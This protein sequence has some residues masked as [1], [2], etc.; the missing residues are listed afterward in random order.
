MYRERKGVALRRHNHEYITSAS[1]CGNWGNWSSFNADLQQK[2]GQED[3]I[4]REGMPSANANGILLLII[5]LTRE[6]IV[7]KESQLEIAT[8]S[9]SE[10]VFSLNARFRRQFQLEKGVGD[11]VALVSVSSP[12]IGL[13]VEP[14]KTERC[15][16]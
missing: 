4:R 5:S 14:A 6:E 2:R 15:F 1:I 7:R 10:P 16:L 12:P 8:L 13:K 3:V 11:I 9:V